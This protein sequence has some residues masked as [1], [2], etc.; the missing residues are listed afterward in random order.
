M[1]SIEPAWHIYESF[2]ELADP[3]IET[4]MR[5]IADDKLK[6]LTIVPILLFSAAHA[7]SD[8][9]LAV[10]AE[11]NALGLH[12]LGQTPSLGTAPSVLALSNTRFHEMAHSATLEGCPEAHCGTGIPPD[13]NT[14]HT[15]KPCPLIGVRSER[16]ALAM[17]GRGTSDPVALNHMRELT[18]LIAA[19]RSIH[20]HNTGFFAGG[21]TTV[22]ELLESAATASFEGQ[23]CDTV[24]VQP[25]LLFEGELMD[26]LRSKVRSMRERFPNRNWILARTLGADRKLAEVF[27]QF[28]RDSWSTLK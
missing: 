13:C 7:K 23:D 28:V 6:Y 11:A 19:E 12:I 17:V 5:Q 24:L 3:S 14:R 18:Q 21:A 4:A 8:I 25:H 22:D 27:L 9:P 26:Q 1:R 10:E 16:I 20:W 2:L 15:C